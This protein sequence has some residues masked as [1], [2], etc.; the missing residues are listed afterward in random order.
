M[1]R[2]FALNTVGSFERVECPLCFATTTYRHTISGEIRV[3]RTKELVP[4]AEAALLAI[5]LSW[6]VVLA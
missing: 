1:I 4:L 3:G 5:V 2:T 6:P